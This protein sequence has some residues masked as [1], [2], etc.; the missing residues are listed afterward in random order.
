MK[1]YVAGNVSCL[2][3]KVERNESDKAIA[4]VPATVCAKE[5]EIAVVT[6]TLIVKEQIII[7]SN[8][9]V[10][11]EVE[12][13]K[14]SNRYGTMKDG[15]IATTSKFQQQLSNLKLKHRSEID[16]LTFQCIN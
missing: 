2:I 8:K 10:T 12:V 15:N 4:V 13:T 14:L 6:E 5:G 11:A 1:L 16:K 3:S 9:I 7:C